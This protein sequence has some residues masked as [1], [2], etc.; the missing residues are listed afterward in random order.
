MQ[1]AR[2]DYATIQDARQLAELVLS[3]D[4][5]TDKGLVARRLA[6]EMLGLDDAGCAPDAM[7][8]TTNGTTRLIPRDEPVFLIRGQDAVGGAAVRAWATLAEANGADPHIVGVA[9]RHAHK[10]D[11]WPKKKTPDLAA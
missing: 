10:M 7:P 11:A 1:H 3:M 4:L 2:S 9:R 5:I 6:R 8:I